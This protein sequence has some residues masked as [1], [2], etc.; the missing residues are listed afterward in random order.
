MAT[1]VHCRYESGPLNGNFLRTGDSTRSQGKRSTLT[2][3]IDV[4]IAAEARALTLDEK[5]L[6]AILLC[7]GN[8]VRADDARSTSK[9]KC[10]LS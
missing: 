4:G 3:C 5:M 7:P 10:W 2:G 9:S 8:L 6:I 1:W